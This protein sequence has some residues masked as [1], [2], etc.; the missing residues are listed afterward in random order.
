MRRA[1]RLRC[2]RGRAAARGM[3]R[4]V[5]HAS[6]RQVV[7]KPSTSTSHATALL[8]TVRPGC[9][10]ATA[11]ASAQVPLE[12]AAD[13][14]HE[15]HE[16]AGSAASHANPVGDIHGCDAARARAD[17]K[18]PA[19]E[20]TAAAA[21]SGRGPCRSAMRPARKGARRK[22]SATVR[23]NAI[24]APPRPVPNRIV[25]G[26]DEHSEGEGGAEQDARSEQCGDD[27]SPSAYRVNLLA[28]FAADPRQARWPSPRPNSLSA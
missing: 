24:A 20:S 25:T 8:A 12:P 9:G 14:R 16:G 17:G 19:V 11:S 28:H 21:S 22:G 15:G 6:T 5:T 26:M 23:A 3:V 27:D 10:K 2:R 1:R 13:G 4:P 18:T 7:R